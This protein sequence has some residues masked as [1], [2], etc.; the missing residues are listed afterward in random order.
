MN[1]NTFFLKFKNTMATIGDG[2]ITLKVDA[3]LDTTGTLNFSVDT[4][5]TV[6]TIDATKSVKLSAT[7]THDFNCGLANLKA[8]T[9]CKF[10]LT[11]TVQNL[12]TNA[13]KYY[14]NDRKQ[15]LIS[16]PDTTNRNVRVNDITYGKNDAANSGNQIVYTDKDVD[17]RLTNANKIGLTFFTL[18]AY[19]IKGTSNTNM[20]MRIYSD[21]NSRTNTANRV[22]SGTYVSTF[23]FYG[24]Q[25]FTPSVTTDNTSLTVTA[26]GGKFYIGGVAQKTLTVLRGTTYTFNVSDSSNSTHVL[27]FSTTSN[28]THGGG[29]LYTTGVSNTNNPGTAG[30]TVTLAVNNSAPDILYYYCTAHSGMG[31][32]II[33][34]SSTSSPFSHTQ[35]LGSNELLLINGLYESF[36]NVYY[37]DYSNY[38]TGLTNATTN[39]TG[40]TGVDIG[41]T[42]YLFATFTITPTGTW[43]AATS[44]LNLTIQ[45]RS[46]FSRTSGTLAESG[47]LLYVWLPSAH[48]SGESFWYNA[49]APFDREDSFVANT[50]AQRK[51]G[52]IPILNSRST[53]GSNLVYSCSIPAN[54]TKENT[55]HVRIGLK[56]DNSSVKKFSG[57]TLSGS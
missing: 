34:R 13:D 23:Q 24:S 26:G 15:L 53:S 30:A 35:A 10:L 16:N 39:L 54:T 21:N 12:A 17:V 50:T 28:G 20:S 18:T 45:N 27:R 56:S 22:S 41:G 49:N 57:I 46:G 36:N 11:T 4:L 3:P 31:G 1:I 14:R 19:N 2:T 48:Y 55:V 40:H 9:G 44:T 7:A 43:S 51:A 25:V 38:N 8:Q 52:L 33:V 32:M 6:P 42:D 29:V 37:I 5:N 47:L